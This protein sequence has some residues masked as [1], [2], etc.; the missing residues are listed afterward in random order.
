MKI[1][2]NN[3]TGE[4][5]WSCARY[6]A[7]KGTRS[8]DR[9]NVLGVSKK[10][11]KKKEELMR[12]FEENKWYII[13]KPEENNLVE[14]SC[15]GKIYWNHGMNGFNEQIA[16]CVASYNDVAYFDA[17]GEW[18]VHLNWA[19]GP[20]ESKAEALRTKMKV[21]KAK[22]CADTCQ[23]HKL[24]PIKADKNEVHLQDSKTG[25]VEVEPVI[26]PPT[27]KKEPTKKGIILKKIRSR[28]KKKK[29]ANTPEPCVGPLHF[30]PLTQDENVCCPFVIKTDKYQEEIDRVFEDYHDRNKRKKELNERINREFEKPVKSSSIWKKTAFTISTAAIAWSAYTLFP[31]VG[32]IHHLGF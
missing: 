8:I 14:D 26:E 31:Y 20:F 9:V 4:R 16:E 12:H 7:C 27:T 24:T 21:K 28:W 3:W 2:R 13:Q 17:L 23:K 25:V 22:R 30:N 18:A 5:F 1:K 29:L 11:K 32:A 10:K 19:K 6:P 15:L